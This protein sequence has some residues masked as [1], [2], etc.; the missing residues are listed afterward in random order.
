MSCGQY[1]WIWLKTVGLY[2]YKFAEKQKPLKVLW[3]W[4]PISSLVWLSGLGRRESSSVEILRRC[5]SIG[6]QSKMLAAEER[7]I[8]YMIETELIYINNKSVQK[9]RTVPL[10]DFY[11][12]II[13]V[14]IAR[15]T[16]AEIFF[17]YIFCI[18]KKILSL[19]RSRHD[20]LLFYNTIYIYLILFPI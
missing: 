15:H 17:F 19:F 6:F 2:D 4:W 13:D 8:S 7:S 16:N 1:I 14:E 10:V 18:E 12:E 9:W 20:S 11:K 5:P 3:V